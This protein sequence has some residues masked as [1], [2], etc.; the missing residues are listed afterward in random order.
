M[1]SS[2]LARDA[3]ELELEAGGGS[4]FLDGAERFLRR[5][6]AW[7]ER[8]RDGSRL[9][10]DANGIAVDTGAACRG[11]LQLAGEGT[12]VSAPSTPANTTTW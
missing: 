11:G 2:R 6:D 4:R 12:R 5:R 1:G 7:I 9:G 3:Q 8:E 10:R